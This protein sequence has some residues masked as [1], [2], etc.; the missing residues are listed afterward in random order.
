[1]KIILMWM[2]TGALLFAVT[3]S[4]AIQEA[5]KNHK[6]ILVEMV[7]EFCP[8][9]QQMD[10]YVLS[11]E[12][13]QM[14]INHKYVFLKLDIEKDEI[15]ALFTSRMTPTFYFVNASGEDILYEIKG[16][17]SKSEFLRILKSINQ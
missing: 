2:F 6:L 17:P 3:F 9:C 15:P 4:D 13:V 10:K 5:E 1:M 11:K 16:A 8:Y 14:V 7:M 12:D